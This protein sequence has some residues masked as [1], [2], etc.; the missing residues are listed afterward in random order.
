MDSS[1]VE[2]AFQ[3]I[4]TEIYRIVLNKAL[5]PSADVIR[6]GGGTAINVSDTNADTSKGGCC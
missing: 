3:K 5:E 1:N 4:L 6:P 2:L